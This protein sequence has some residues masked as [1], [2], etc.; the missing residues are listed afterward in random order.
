MVQLTDKILPFI[1][2]AVAVSTELGMEV[3]VFL[4]E[5]VCL[6]KLK[7]SFPTREAF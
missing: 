3:F 6:T 2:R 7:K 5:L 1:V 4:R